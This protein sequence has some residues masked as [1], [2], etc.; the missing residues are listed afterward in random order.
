MIRGAWVLGFTGVLWL[1]R[2]QVN[3]VLL[4]IGLWWGYSLFAAL[5]SE[6]PYPHYLLQIVPAM[7]LGLGMV[8]WLRKYLE[9]V[10]VIGL[11]LVTIWGIRVVDFW[12]YESRAYYDN[13]VAYATGRKDLAEYRS[14]FWAEMNDTYATEEYLSGKGADDE[15]IFVW[16]N[17]SAVMAL[18]HHPAITKYVVAYHVD[19]F[20]GYELTM[21]QLEAAPPR[22]IVHVGRPE[23]YF[24]ELEDF[25]NENYA[26]VW[27][28]GIHTVY[29]QQLGD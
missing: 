19:D 20:V 14:Y 2:K 12:K 4:L 15:P 21:D 24:P 22:Y 11:L 28:R 7:A 13:F 29:E 23:Y 10:M 8:V 5:L 26:V 9:Q 18:G 16:S 25:T 1:I 3:P 6:R 17:K 27:N